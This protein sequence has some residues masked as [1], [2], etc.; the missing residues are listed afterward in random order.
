MADLQ[1]KIQD[2]FDWLRGQYDESNREAASPDADDA[3][4]GWRDGIELAFDE[5]KNNF[6]VKETK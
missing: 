5:F 6:D 1:Q 4:V 2:Y 3:T